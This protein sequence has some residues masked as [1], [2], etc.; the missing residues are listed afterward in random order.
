MAVRRGSWRTARPLN[1]ANVADLEIFAAR[2]LEVALTLGTGEGTFRWAHLKSA[3]IWRRRLAPEPIES[4][5]VPSGNIMRGHTT[6]WDGVFAKS[7]GSWRAERE[8]L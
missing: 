6:F 3:N 1:D 5:T 2:K 7:N 8:L 4:V